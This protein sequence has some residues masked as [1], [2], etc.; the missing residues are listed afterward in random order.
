VVQCHPR[1][2]ELVTTKKSATKNPRDHLPRETV[3][4]ELLRYALLQPSIAEH[5]RKRS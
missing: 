1:E 4:E 2:G 5:W 3:I